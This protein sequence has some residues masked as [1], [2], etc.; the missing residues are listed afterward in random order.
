MR[1]ATTTQRACAGAP[2]VAV[3]PRGD[4]STLQSIM[5]GTEAD[6]CVLVPDL[7]PTAPWKGA[8]QNL[9]KVGSTVQKIQSLPLF[10]P[11]NQDWTWDQRTRDS[12]L[13]ERGCVP[14]RPGPGEPDRTTCTECY[15]VPPRWL[16]MTKTPRPRDLQFSSSISTMEAI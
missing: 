6:R 8:R 10:F 15:R 14:S 11:S 2:E 12:E 13:E 9:K 16:R 7:G 5:K 1:A 4:S 3:Q